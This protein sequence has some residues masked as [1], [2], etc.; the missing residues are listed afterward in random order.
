MTS[1]IEG[2]NSPLARRE[3]F[4]Y[5]A[6]IARLRNFVFDSSPPPPRLPL[7]LPSLAP[8]RRSLTNRLRKFQGV[9]K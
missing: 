4:S 5:A 2:R 8:K 7:I 6:D 1:L 3:Y 9:S